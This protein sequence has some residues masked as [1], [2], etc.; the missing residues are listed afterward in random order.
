MAT[1]ANKLQT[2]GLSYGRFAHW[3]MSL[4][5]NKAL[6]VAAEADQSL[7]LVGAE[8]GRLV[9]K[10]SVQMSLMACFIQPLSSQAGAASLFVLPSGRAPVSQ[11]RASRHQPARP[12]TLIDVCRQHLSILAGL[13]PYQR[14]KQVPL[15][16]KLSAARVSTDKESFMEVTIAVHYHKHGFLLK[17]T[18]YT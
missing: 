1:A 8:L 3:Q 2:G 10:P 11:C 7:G 13:M 16:Q 15:N 5:L 4:H 12:Q 9:S 14:A 6:L 18:C 17:V